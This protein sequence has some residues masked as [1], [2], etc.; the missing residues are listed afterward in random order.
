MTLRN[1]LRLSLVWYCLWAQV[2][3]AQTLV[4]KSIPN[5]PTDLFT[6]ELRTVQVMVLNSQKFLELAQS[7]TPVH[8]KIGTEH[9]WYLQL[10][11]DP[12]FSPDYTLTT[13]TPEGIEKAWS[14]RVQTFAGVIDGV[15]RGKCR[16]TLA[17]NF[18]YG[19]FEFEDRTYFIEP[20]RRSNQSL[21]D[22]Q[23]LFYEANDIL[24][25]ANGHCAGALFEQDK[26][27]L[28]LPTEKTNRQ[29]YTVEV[30]IAA[31]YKMLQFFNQDVTLLEKY[32]AA[33]L[34]N[35]RANYD[36]EFTHQ[37]RFEIVTM[38]VATCATCDPW[39]EDTNYENLLAIFRDWGNANGFAKTF[40]VGTLW[41]GRVLDDNIGGGGY[42]GVLCGRLRYNVLRR[43]SENA[44]LMRALQAHELGHNLN[45]RHDS[46]NAPTIMAPF[47]RDVHAWSPMSQVSINNYFANAL[48]IRNC[49]SPCVETAPTAD[50]FTFKTKG[51][52]PLEIQFYN[53]SSANATEWEW[54]FEGGTPSTT[55][56]VNP[57]VTYEKP[58]IYAVTLRVGNPSGENQVVKSAFV[59]VKGP[60]VPTFNINYQVGTTIASF[61]TAVVADS[62]R[63]YW[64]DNHTDTLKTVNFDFQQDG[65]YPITL[66]TFNECGADTL[67]QQLDIITPPQAAFSAA[68]VI[69]CAPL[70]VQFNNESSA[71]ASEFAWQFSGGNPLTSNEKNP[72]VVFERPGVYSVSL[73]ARNAAGEVTRRLSNLVQVN[74]VPSAGFSTRIDQNVV[75]FRNLSEGG[76]VHYWDFGDGTSA[77]STNPVHTY[78]TSGRFTVQL[79]TRNTCGSDTITKPVEITGLPPT[80]VF[81]SETRQG[82]TPLTLRF[83]DQSTNEPETWEWQFPG[84]EPASS[85]EQHPTVTYAKPGIY[86]VQLVTSNFFG[87]DTL[88]EAFYLQLTEKPSVDFNYT[89][90]QQQITLQ[91]NDV[92]QRGWE[93]VWQFGDGNTSEQPE[94]THSYESPGP[95]EITLIVHN[96]CG[97]DTTRKTVQIGTTRTQEANWLEELSLYPNPSNGHFMLLLKGAPQQ[98][99]H[100]RTLNAL[101]QALQQQMVDFYSGYWQQYF[102]FQYLA[103]GVY[104]LEIQSDTGIVKK[105]FIVQK[106]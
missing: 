70:T 9:D 83:T 49:L 40:D 25:N 72:I 77:N 27:E 41:T 103:A 36:N 71:N 42:Y 98:R 20:A 96:E 39:G 79:I 64:G 5:I 90:Q 48:T 8:L 93:Y 29:C 95:Y 69:G 54:T 19:V 38:W 104:W 34:N 7:G 56:N 78:Q 82:C 28:L 100:I 99:L 66:V 86:S 23:Y 13:A 22:D 18:I 92:V 75:A 76:M 91:L 30:A 51:C 33:N 37:I 45:A 60:P 55:T 84:G 26:G 24:P 102:D 62:L 16:L 80:T 17:E 35:V 3:G 15:D 68:N 85:T 105:A 47:I 97:A 94:P 10:T 14:S 57:L 106:P 89:I 43:Y 63:W 46:T 101:G 58:G 53:T 4:G 59:E 2:A 21:G 61:S 12:I 1:F 67:T 88:Y 32:V 65:V 81:T 87:T 74:D 6:D 73:V 52:A 50:F 44:G 11:P 31:D